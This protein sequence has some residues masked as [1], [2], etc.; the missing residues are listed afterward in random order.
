MQATDILVSEHEVILSVV[1]AL[2][3]AADRLEA[4]APIRPGFFED[5]AA[6]FKGF[7]D[8]CHH[9]KEEGALFPAIE[10][11][12][13]AAQNGPVGVM[14]SEHEQSRAYI[15]GLREAAQRLGA[16]DES[17]RAEVLSNA[18]GYARLLRQHI[19]KENTVLFPLAGRLIPADEHDA[20]LDA[21]ERVEHE[22]TGEGVHEKYLALAEALRSEA[23]LVVAQ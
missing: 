8:G 15:R 4:G 22:E 18:R 11:H 17:A 3:A 2:E 12:S 9:A 14:L 6:F 21:F 19:L 5:A 7:A 10:K 16:G 1:E 23:G 13:P 20:V